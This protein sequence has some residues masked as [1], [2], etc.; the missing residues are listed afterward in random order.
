M[1]E[2]HEDLRLAR[3]LVKDALSLRRQAGRYTRSKPA[4]G[5]KQAMRR[6]SREL[7]D[8]ARRIERQT[9]EHILDGAEVLCATLTGLDDELLDDRRFEL[10]VIDE[11]GQSTEP[12]MWIPLA[13]AGRLVLAGDHYQLPPTVIS[14]EAVGRRLRD[15]FARA[16]GDRR[17]AGQPRFGER[18]RFGAGAGA[19]HVQS[20]L[21][22]A[23]SHARGDSG[24]FESR[25]LSRIADAAT[26]PWRNIYWPICRGWNAR[27]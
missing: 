25:V 4:P 23:I 21:D 19:H 8:D 5:S 14:P 7:M 13:R 10:V 26:I 15:Q 24:F 2:G 9:V 16:F 12:P 20:P 1:V 18:L 11:A 6:E 17:I 27:G 22:D 3:K